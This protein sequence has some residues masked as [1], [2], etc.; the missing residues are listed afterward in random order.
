VESRFAKGK[1][2]QLTKLSMVFLFSEG[3]Y[4]W[5]LPWHTSAQRARAE[6][7]AWFLH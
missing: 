3:A 5:L 1:H 6:D 7:P 4:S 2:A